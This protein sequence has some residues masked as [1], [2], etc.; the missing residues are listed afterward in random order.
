IDLHKLFRHE[1][2]IRFYG[3]KQQ[4]SNCYLFLEYA[5]GG[6]LFDKIEPDVG[7]PEYLAQHYF[8]QVVAGMVWAKTPYRGEPVDVWSCGVILT[9]MLTGELPWDQPSYPNS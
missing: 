4:H 8:K 1:N 9:A 2:I 6:E 7:M 5:A 3:Y